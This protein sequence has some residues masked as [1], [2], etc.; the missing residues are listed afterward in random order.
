MHA[1]DP[2]QV[3]MNA[4]WRTPLEIAQSLI[5]F[6]QEQAPNSV[7]HVTFSG[8][9]PA[10]HN[11]IHAALCFKE[12]GW[13]IAVETQGT[14]APDWLGLVDTL[15]VSPKGP[16]MGANTDLNVLDYFVGRTFK[17]KVAT[18]TNIKV[19]IF[20]ERDLE[21]ARLIHERYHKYGFNCY[22][23][24]GNTRPPGRD[25]ELSYVGH[26]ME[27]AS[28]YRNLFE[29]IKNDPLLS[30]WRFLPQWHVFVWGNQKGK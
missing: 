20:D 3:R 1:V 2:M 18:R 10:I 21:F 15:T 13:Q 7:Q 11:L 4:V 24:L 14:F 22:L 27:L 16:G 17:L 9:N 25:S 29:D 19:V 12:N 5:G 23:S 30:Q 28:H 8:G 6:R 26:M